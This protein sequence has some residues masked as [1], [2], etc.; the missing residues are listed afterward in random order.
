MTISGARLR[1]MGFT[2]ITKTIT[3]KK[4][5]HYLNYWDSLRRSS[6]MDRKKA[7][8]VRVY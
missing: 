5:G 6:R 8:L 7:C 1:R 2:R 3:G 4:N